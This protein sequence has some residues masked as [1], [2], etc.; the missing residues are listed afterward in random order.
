M[1]ER[2]QRKIRR[3][4]GF[5]ADGNISIHHVQVLIHCMW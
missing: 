2:V 1:G 3:R 5:A 4:D